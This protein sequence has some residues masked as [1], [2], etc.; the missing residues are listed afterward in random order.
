MN[1]RSVRKS[2]RTLQLHRETVRL[3]SPAELEG[4]GGGID[5]Y[6]VNRPTVLLKPKTN[7]WSSD[8][9][10]GCGA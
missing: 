5:A 8:I 7:G 3:L 9:D 1:P 2:R 10:A 6:A 4:I